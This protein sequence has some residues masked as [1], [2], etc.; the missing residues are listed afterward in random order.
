MKKRASIPGVYPSVR[1]DGTPYYRASLTY[2]SKH[3][4]LG[5]YSTAEEAGAAYEQACA[6]LRDSGTEQLLDYGRAGGVLPYGKWVALINLRDN[7]I[8]C[9]G[10]IYL[11]NKYFEYYVDQDT[12]LRFDASEL[13]YYTHHSIQRRGGHFFVADYG[14]QLNVLNRYGIHSYSVAGRDYFFKNGDA[15]DFRSGNVVILNRYNGVRTEQKRGRNTFTTRIHVIGDLVVGHY[16]DETD[17]A[18]AYNKAADMLEKAGIRGNFNRNYLED[19]ST[20]EYRIRYERLRIS[21]RIKA[22]VTQL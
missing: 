22:L 14:S 15:L 10:P 1:K 17:A 4:S 2:N 9:G 12:V 6:I 7:G 5:S 20:T 19:L 3:I 8:Y 13:F 16:D 21:K 11:R 18:I